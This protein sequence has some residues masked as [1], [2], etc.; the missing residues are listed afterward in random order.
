[1]AC[2]RVVTA[3]SRTAEATSIISAYTALVPATKATAATIHATT[4]SPAPTMRHDFR[5][6]KMP[7]SHAAAETVKAANESITKDWDMTAAESSIACVAQSADESHK[8]RPLLT[9]TAVQTKLATPTTVVINTGVN[10]GERGDSAH[11]VQDCIM[12]VTV[13]ILATCLN[14]K[15]KYSCLWIYQKILN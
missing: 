11:A 15:V 14:L 10:G 9:T 2:V 13:K 12:K 4:R 7:L 1:M 5:R 8:P 3:K 6:V